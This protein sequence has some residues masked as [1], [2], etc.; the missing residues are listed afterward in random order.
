MN[1][2]EEQSGSSATAGAVAG[3]SGGDQEKGLVSAVMNKA[4]G[5][6]AE[7]VAQIPKPEASLERVSFKGV[8]RECITLHSHVDVTNP[9]GH[10]IPICEI[11]YT[12]KSAGKYV[13]YFARTRSVMQ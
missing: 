9:Y 6:V 2:A 5:F 10:R 8:S 12:F 11:T 3:S 1:A 7:K 13:R 4:K